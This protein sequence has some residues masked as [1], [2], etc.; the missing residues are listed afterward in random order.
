[1]V[2]C[3][4]PG[5]GESGRCIFAG[6]RFCTRGC[7]LFPLD[8]LKTFLR[9]DPSVRA[10]LVLLLVVIVATALSVGMFLVELR[11]KELLRSQ[12]MML[13]LGRVLADQTTRTFEGVTLTMGGARDRLSDVIGLRVKLDDPMVGALLRARIAG[14]PQIKSMFVVGADGRLQNSSRT[15]FIPNLGVNDR[16]FFKTFAD[17]SKADFFISGPERARIDGRWAFYVSMPLTDAQG[18]FRGVLASAVSIDYF[19]A[20][21]DTAGLDY[22]S[23]IYLLDREGRRLAGKTSEAAHLGE[24]GVDP[25]LL[26]E[27]LPMEKDAVFLAEKALAGGRWFYAYRTV[28]KYPLVISLAFDEREALVDWR[29][30]MHQVAFGVAL[31]LMLVS[32]ATALLIRNLLRKSRLEKDLRERDA[33]VRHL[34]ESVSDAIVSIDADKRVVLLNQAAEKLFDVSTDRVV[35]HDVTDLLEG[36][37]IQTATSLHQFLDMGLSSPDGLSL[38]GIIDGMGGNRQT[39]FEISLS[40]SI[41]GGG[42][43]LTAVF[44]DLSDRLRTERELQESNRQLQTLS[45]SLQDVREAERAR[46]S[47]ELH[48]ELGQ[49]LTGIRL[50]VSWLGGRLRQENHPLA[51]KVGAVKAQIDQTI[52]S[53]RKISS[54]LRPLVLDDLGFSAA[55]S[56]Y[57]D[58]FSSRTG[59]PV[60]LSLPD[61]DPP[62]GSAL[63]TALFRVMQE[64]LTNVARHAGA[65]H[66]AVSLTLRQGHW[67]LAIRDDG[68]GFVSG[69]GTARGIGLLGMRERVQ[70]LGGEF[71]VRTAP[72][73]GTEIEAQIP[74]EVVQG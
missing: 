42:T 14:L 15:D 54:E 24:R 16:M 5:T 71:A 4:R 17:G 21:Y 40:A 62:H 70:M 26:N 47:R 18:V 31:A 53:V 37:S 39:P 36:A 52:A 6:R 73:Q 30:I 20:L 33:L 32:A 65:N 59:I 23:S 12:Q 8:R 35:G 45:A 49:L 43:L 67:L 11:Q 57:A 64:S 27:R 9:G 46:I 50:E 22:V 58:Q 38:V 13:G 3:L 25:T 34:V 61:Q 1:M 69:S 68:C 51:A 29:S 74:F 19:A 63:A 66:V 28:D 10:I 41:F 60:E 44:R 7:P 55:A 48:D 56:W 72:A 2:L